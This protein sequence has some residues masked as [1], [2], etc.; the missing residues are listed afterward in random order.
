MIFM[1]AQDQ[2]LAHRRTKSQTKS[3]SE[4]V[5]H[6]LFVALSGLNNRLTHRYHLNCSELQYYTL[7]KRLQP[8]N[9]TH[10]HSLGS[11]RRRALNTAFFGA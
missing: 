3:S 4:S 6:F 9:K 1:A 8:T 7:L 11:G 2:G 10:L 5:S